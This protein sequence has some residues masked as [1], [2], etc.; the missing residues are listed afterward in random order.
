M[1]EGMRRM[2][3]AIVLASAV[4]LVLA[5]VRGAAQ[6]S[7]GEAHSD[8]DA[9]P[10]GAPDPATEG[11][12]EDSVASSE[13]NDPLAEEEDLWLTRRQVWEDFIRHLRDEGHSEL[14]DKWQPDPAGPITVPDFSKGDPIRGVLF[15][16]S[17]DLVNLDSLFDEEEIRRLG[18]DERDRRVDELLARL[19]GESDA[20]IQDWA[21][22][23][24]ARRALEVGRDDEARA[25]LE[26]LVRSPRWLSSREARRNL[27]GVYQRQGEDTLA[28][29]ELQFYLLE[30]D[31]EDAEERFWAEEQLRAIRE[32]PHDGP[33]H[34]VADRATKL[35]DRIRRVEVG[36]PTQEDQE[37]V[38][39]ILDKVAVLLEDLAAQNPSNA[40]LQSLTSSS[41]SSQSGQ[42]RRAGQLARN[43]QAQQGR[44]GQN[45]NQNGEG[46]PTGNRPNDQAAQDTRL[47]RG[48]AGD[49][50]LRDPDAPDPNDGPWGQINDR[51][52]AKSLREGWAR[53]PPAYRDLV[54]RYFRDITDLE[55]P[56]SSR[57]SREEKP[58]SSGR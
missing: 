40:E 54:A 15:R 57:R 14:A 22:Y 43:R 56:P 55:P 41:S 29:L 8:D 42:G 32:K 11:V 19:D 47:T 24:R 7:V 58:S 52:V 31:E 30:L 46:D 13:L 3:P 35:S 5:S 12:E 36:T 44:N 6:D 37:E 38:E 48:E 27:A 51:E 39:D 26:K 53:I 4:F 10:A 17:N 33:L 49:S 45:Q 2:R 1:T 28:V 18:S 50:A 21:R 34:D 9:A 25:A 16:L 20:Y 23:Y